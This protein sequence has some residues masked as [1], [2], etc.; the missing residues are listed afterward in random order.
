[1]VL[2]LLPLIRDFPAAAA[3]AAAGADGRELIF[4][5]SGAGFL[6]IEVLPGPCPCSVWAPHEQSPPPAG[7]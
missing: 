7:L 5:G 4:A 6:R 1:M 3:A 2:P